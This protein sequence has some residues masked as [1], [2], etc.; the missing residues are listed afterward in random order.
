MEFTTSQDILLR[1]LQRIQGIVEKK[2]TLPILSHFLLT[3]QPDTT[4]IHATDLELGYKGYL[5]TTVHSPGTVTLPA[6]KTYDILRELP[7]GVDVTLA[8]E[9]PGWV[10]IT[11]G[12]STFKVPCLPAEEYPALPAV[13]EAE[14]SSLDNEVLGEMIRQT[15]FATAHD[16]TRPALSGVL[17]TCDSRELVMV[18]TDGHR[19]AHSRRPVAFGKD[20]RVIVPRKALEEVSRFAADGDEPAM[21]VAPLRNHLV[22]RKGRATLVTR[23]I[24]G[25]FPDYEGVV[26]KT[27]GRHAT[28]E[29]ERLTRALR[30]VSL[31]SHE[32]TKPV[33]VEF[34]PDN[35]TLRSNTPEM[36][37]ATEHIPAEYEGEDMVMGFNARYLLD[38][39]AVTTDEHVVLDLNDPLSPGVIRPRSSEQYFY[40]IMPMRV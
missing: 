7:T 2:N 24:E 5:E 18:A 13:E 15:L 9:T 38:A 23:L 3:A 34:S 11:A 27:F 35:L 37:E 39:L 1:G 30:R 4:L 29:H 6:R 10:H 40:V 28:V 8:A 21:D 31:L 32:K 33:R 16:E 12:S 26:P 22:F 25:Q 17:M 36:G 19:L 20:L 14:F